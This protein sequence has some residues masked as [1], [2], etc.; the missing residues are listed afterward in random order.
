[1]KVSEEGPQK[2][3]LKS[4]SAVQRQVGLDCNRL[5]RG[6][7]DLLQNTNTSQVISHVL[8]RG[9]FLFTPYCVLIMDYGG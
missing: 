4:S 2:R 9:S 5:R 7:G 3:R 8:S 6:K 1:M